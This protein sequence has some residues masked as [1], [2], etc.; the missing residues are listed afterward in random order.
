MWFYDCYQQNTNTRIPMKNKT[1]NT[2][3]Y[4]GL[5]IVN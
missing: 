1:S 2:K 3:G 4:N 5:I